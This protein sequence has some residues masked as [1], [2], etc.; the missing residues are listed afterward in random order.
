MSNSPKKKEKQNTE[1]SNNSKILRKN[2]VSDH[3]NLSESKVNSDEKES[4]SWYHYAIILGV[5]VLLVLVGTFVSEWYYQNSEVDLNK[6]VDMNETYVYKFKKGNVTYN[7][8][9]GTSQTELEKFN[10]SI[11]PNKYDVLN[12]LN[13]RFS[14]DEYNGSDNGQ[15]SMAAIKL[16]RF[17]ST[18]Y[19]FK[20]DAN[21]SFQS[22]ENIT[23]ANSTLNNKVVTFNP[24]SSESGVF[25]NSNGCLN[26]NS[27]SPNLL[28]F[29]IDSFMVEIMED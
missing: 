7:V 16:R 13:F 17:L 14:F 5:L 24:R 27:T 26:I 8:Q 25:L 10:F 3:K 18:V 20:F 2:D 21:S 1:T 6:T 11:Q 29:V 19:N 23:C 9:L 12:T 28:P 15:V 4:P 22:T